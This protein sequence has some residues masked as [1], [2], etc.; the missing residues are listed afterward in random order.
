MLW[1]VETCVCIGYPN[2]EISSAFGGIL[3]MSHYIFVLCEDK[4]TILGLKLSNWYKSGNSFHHKLCKAIFSVF[5]NILVPNISILHILR[6][7]LGRAEIFCSLEMVPCYSPSKNV[8]YF[9]SLPLL[10]IIMKSFH[11]FLHVQMITYK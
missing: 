1:L 6:S 4:V 3:N 9:C 7:S 10:W 11:D 2:T 5:Y 8:I